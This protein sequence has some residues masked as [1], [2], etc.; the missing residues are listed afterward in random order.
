MTPSKWYDKWLLAAVALAILTAI[1]S[2]EIALSRG[3]P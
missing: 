1:G 2:L 3:L